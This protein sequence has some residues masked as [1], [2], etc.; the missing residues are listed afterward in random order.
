MN[1]RPVLHRRCQIDVLIVRVGAQ[2]AGGFHKLKH[3]EVG[4]DGIDSRLFNSP[5]DIGILNRRAFLNSR[6]RLRLLT[7]MQ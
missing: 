6:R 4:G 1:V 5:A 3:P 7:K 2:A